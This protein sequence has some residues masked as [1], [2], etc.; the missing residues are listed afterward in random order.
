M[1]RYSMKETK[2]FNH[3]KA[4][5]DPAYV[6]HLMLDAV[7]R[8]INA[9]ND[10]DLARKLAISPAAVSRLRNKA[11]ITPHIILRIIEATG[12]TFDEVLAALG[13]V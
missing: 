10:A 8:R 7:A 1:A 6:P 2:F 13:G 11:P 4:A 9:R 3:L 5:K 12:W